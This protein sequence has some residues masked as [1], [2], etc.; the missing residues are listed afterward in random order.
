MS[1]ELAP[2]IHLPC[3]TQ[4]QRPQKAPGPVLG[5]WLSGPGLPSKGRSLFAASVTSGRGSSEEAS[6]QLRQGGCLEEVA[7]QCRA[8]R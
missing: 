5:T 6:N 2:A 1:A 8:E 7:A 4:W 3:H